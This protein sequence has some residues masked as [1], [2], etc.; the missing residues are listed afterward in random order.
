MF[1]ASTRRSWSVRPESG[2]VTAV[3]HFIVATMPASPVVD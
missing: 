3:G 1:G 2:A